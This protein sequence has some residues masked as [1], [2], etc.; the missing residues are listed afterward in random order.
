MARAVSEAGDPS[1]TSPP[2]MWLQTYNR[3][4][5]SSLLIAVSRRLALGADDESSQEEVAD[6]RPDPITYARSIVAVSQVR[7]RLKCS[8]LTPLVLV[9]TMVVLTCVGCVHPLC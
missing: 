3:H 2:Q 1:H 9:M 5:E 7:W 8:F 6:K 4:K